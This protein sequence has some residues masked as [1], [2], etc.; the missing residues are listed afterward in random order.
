MMKGK[1]FA[2]KYVNNCDKYGLCAGRRRKPYEPMRM[3]MK[4]FLTTALVL[5][6][7]GF[8]FTPS[9]LAR[10]LPVYGEP[11]EDG[12]LYAADAARILRGSADGTLTEQTRPD[13]DLTRNGEIDETDARAALYVACGK[14]VDVVSFGERVSSSICSERLFDRFCYT[15]TLDD[16]AGNYRSDTVCVSVVKGRAETSDYTLADIYVQDITCIRTV[17]G[18]GDYKGGAQTVERMFDT[19]PDA[20]VG[21]NGDY[22]TQHYYGPVVRNGVTYLDRVTSSWDIA[23][24]LSGGE[25]VTYPYRTLKK[26]DFAYLD[27]YQSWVFGPA[28]LDE[29][30][31]AKTR[32]RSAVTAANPRSVLGYYEPGHYAF[33]AV[34]GR[35]K[36]STGLTMKQ[37]SQLC[38]DL[39]F[40]RAYNLD[41]G[42][43]SVLITQAGPINNPYHDGRPISDIIVVRDVPMD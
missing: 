41:G 31:H 2:L 3:K 1:V 27:T 36:A 4:A 42:Q 9:A 5:F 28:L 14:I 8:A 6:C 13:L 25:L 16:G 21:M 40:A 43:S 26:D 35:S 23:V 20:I 18:G 39:G 22:Y 34:D 15:G 37:L 29:E 33:L 32:F 7:A 10:E 12:V 17:F 11:A 38:E 24:L 19:V 30:G